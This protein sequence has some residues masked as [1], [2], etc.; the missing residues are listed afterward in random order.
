[1]KTIIMLG[2]LSLSMFPDKHNDQSTILDKVSDIDYLMGKYDPADYNEFVLIP[3]RFTTKDNIYLRKEVFEAYQNMYNAALREGLLLTL[4][5]A[6]RNFDY[7]KELWESKW[8]SINHDPK[9]SN[10][11]ELEKVLK[12]LKYS[13]MPGASRHHWGTDIDICDLNDSYFQNGIGK[14]IYEWLVNNA[15]KFG[16]CQTYTKFGEGRTSGYYEEKWHWSYQPM[17]KVFVQKAKELLSNNMFNGFPG[18]EQAS[19]ISIIDNYVLGVNED[20][21]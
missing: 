14:R 20:C 21:L 9:N 10:L 11:S 17:S 13:A 1:M 15:D 7:Q 16:F 19:N 12:I 18:A 3:A 2:L 4:E 8:N 5:S 6:T